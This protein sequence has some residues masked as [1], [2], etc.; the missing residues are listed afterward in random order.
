MKGN[1]WR[2]K[3]GDYLKRLFPA[4]G[5]GDMAS[6]TDE[7]ER[8]RRELTDQRR[9]NV[10]A[11]RLELDMIRRE[12][13]A[14][15]QERLAPI[16]QEMEL[17]RNEILEN[18]AAIHRLEILTL[19]RR[20]QLLN[21][22]G[23][24][25]PPSNPGKTRKSSKP[26][27]FSFG[28][29]TNGKRNEK[30]MRLVDTIRAQKL[31]THRYEI[32]VAGCVEAIKES[33]GLRTFPMEKAAAEG[34]LGAM[35]NVL[36]RSAHFNKLVSLDDDLLLHAGWSEA[37]EEVNEDFDLATGIIVNPDLT[38]YCDWVNSVDNYTFLRPYHE[39]FDKCQ[40]LTGGYGIYKDYVF[41]KNAWNDDLGFYQ[42]E[43]VTFSRKLFD[44]GFE[45]K[46]IAKAVV[47]H[48][49]ERYRQKGYGVIRRQ[50][51]GESPEDSESE[52]TLRLEKLCPRTLS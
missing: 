30:L 44:S 33:E 4:S 17:L 41:E 52:N 46:F 43:D 21:D 34:R 14:D 42:G 1:G 19:G 51:P 13:M 35:R 11:M 40:Y 26:R 29:I 28:I 16:R 36:A 49:D 24:A 32:M 3:V 31:A 10:D 20:I 50:A 12:L 5:N 6:L 18:I 15:D 2:F 47:M 22:F 27:G 37:V 25:F 9:G 48:D 8:L 38:R 7:I 23:K 39:R 45:L